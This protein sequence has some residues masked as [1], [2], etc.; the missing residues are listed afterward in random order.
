MGFS[1]AK[2]ALPASPQLYDPGGKLSPVLVCTASE[3]LHLTQVTMLADPQISQ[4]CAWSDLEELRL[5]P[6]E[7]NLLLD[8]VQGRRYLL[9]LRHSGGLEAR[10]KLKPLFL[11]EDVARWFRAQGLSA[12][13]EERPEAGWPEAPTP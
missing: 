9:I 1:R 11:P 8:L 5:Q 3:V 10:F 4:V 7:T 12:R 2:C 6:V 13:I